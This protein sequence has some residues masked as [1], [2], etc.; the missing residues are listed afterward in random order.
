MAGAEDPG[1]GPQAAREVAP[2]ASEGGGGRTGLRVGGWILVG[3]GG[4]LVLSA[5]A[6]VVIHLTQRGKDGYYTSSTLQVAAPGYAVTSE[7]LHIGDLPSVA[8]DVIGQ[9][10]VSARPYEMIR[11]DV[12][13]RT[14]IAFC[15]GL[16]GRRWAPAD[17]IRRRS[18]RDRNDDMGGDGCPRALDLRGVAGCDH[19]RAVPAEVRYGCGGAGRGVAGWVAGA[20]ACVLRGGPDRVRVVPG[21]GCGGD[22][23]SGD[24]AE[25]DAASL[26]GPAQVRSSRYRS[27]VAAV[28][29]RR[30]DGGGGP[31]R[32]VRGGPRSRAGAG[33]GSP[34]SDA[35]SAP[36]LEAAATPRPRVGPLGVDEGAS[37]VA[38]IA[39]LRASQ[40]G[41]GVHR[42]P[43]G[44]RRAECPSRRARRAA[45]PGR[46]R[47]GVLAG[48][49]PAPRVP[50][51]RH[52]LGADPAARGRGL[53]EVPPR[54]AARI[55]AGAGALPRAVRRV[56]RARVDHE[57]RLEV[58][59]ADPCR[60]RLALRPPTPRRAAMGRRY[61]SG[62][63]LRTP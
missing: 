51:D 5:V 21:G 20:G 59:P 57:D 45:L 41:A 40:H 42:Q 46:D 22:R 16:S 27:V 15:G 50:R 8:N 39:D 6:L 56:R 25:Q 30:V 48:R 62:S 35:L 44:V 55:V 26:G 7:G 53:R 47:P 19:R 32:D 1:A 17:P 43:R 9:V 38:G 18:G 60:G 23:L 52:P 11:R 29:G 31:V 61:S 34:G 12:E 14:S 49:S 2:R 10:R 33:A 4:L 37:R 28:D 63:R 54:G 13:G 3:F 24:R 58:R 36:A